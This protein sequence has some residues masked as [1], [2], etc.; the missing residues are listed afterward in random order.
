MP[1]RGGAVNGWRTL[2]GRAAANRPRDIVAR[3]NLEIFMR[4]LLPFA[5]AIARL[6]S[7]DGIG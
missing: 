2:R 4:P 3:H 7:R 6:S 5:E 1:S